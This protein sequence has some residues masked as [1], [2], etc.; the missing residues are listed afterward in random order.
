[1]SE[2]IILSAENCGGCQ[3]IKSLIKDPSKV[4]ILDVTKS[5][6]AALL[7]AN[8]NIFSIPT[9]VEKT[10]QGIQKCD[11]SIDN[12]KRVRVKCRNKEIIL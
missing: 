7:A 8:N 10:P 1:M 11:L 5:D 12:N 2:I 3:K 9:A 4:K 6:E